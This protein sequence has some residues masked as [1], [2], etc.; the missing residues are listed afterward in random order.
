MT[1]RFLGDDAQARL[2]QARFDAVRRLGEIAAK[3]AA[4]FVVVCGDVFE[5][6]QVDRRT[7]ARALD[8]LAAIPVPVFLLPG[9]HDPLDGGSVF[10]AAPFAEHVPDHVHVLGDRVP[11]VVRPGVE[12][13]GAPWT[14]KRPDVDLVAATCAELEP[15]PGTIRILVA[16]GAVDALA[17][18]RDDP[19]TIHLGA[20]ESALAEGRIHYLALGDRHSRTRVGSTGRVYYAGAPEPTDFDE[21]DPGHALE[22]AVD[23]EGVEVTPHRLGTWHFVRRERIPV[24]GTGDLDALED[25]LAELP[26][27]ERSVLRLSFEGT[28]DLRAA[29]R[30][31]AIVERAADRF[32]AVQRRERGASLAVLPVDADF[33]ELDLA[34]FGRRAVDDLRARAAGSGDEARVARDA[35]AL[36]VRLADAGGAAPARDAQ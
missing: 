3:T 24:N 7:V 14:S 36:L 29:D 34:G 18:D 23:A 13:V 17:P 26:D 30:L 12:V 22:V 9:N 32:A 11:R 27:R 28:L 2:A 1:R 25:W 31:D 10:R 5:S 20:V 35:L 6:S 33:A 16:H 21:V 4:E 15:A 19:A 8:A